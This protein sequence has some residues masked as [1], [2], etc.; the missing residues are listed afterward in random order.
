MDDAVCLGRDVIEVNPEFWR[1]TTNSTKIVECI[2]K[3][4]CDGGYNPNNTHPVNCAEGY[5]GILCTECQVTATT[6][7]QKFND[8]EC[9]E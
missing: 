7:Y 6:K 9:Q 4:A 3:D 8:F 1:M 5:K 2:N